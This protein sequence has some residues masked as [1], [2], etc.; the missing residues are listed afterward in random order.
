MRKET[1]RTLREASKCLPSEPRGVQINPTLLRILYQ[2]RGYSQQS[3]ADAVG[4][5]IATIQNW[6]WG[7]CRPLQDNFEN[8]CKALDVSPNMLEL[9][10]ASLVERGRHTRIA[11]FH[12]KELLGTNEPPEYREVQLVEADLVDASERESAEEEV[13][14]ESLTIPRTEQP[15]D[16][17]ESDTAEGDAV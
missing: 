10:T 11:R 16:A 4:V 3:L 1:N 8:L 7:R 9:T 14:R 15:S 2:E 17:T 5:K 13:R 12:A 6:L